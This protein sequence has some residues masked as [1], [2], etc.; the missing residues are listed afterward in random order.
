MRLSVN[1]NKI[2]LLRNQRDLGFPSV[3]HFSR[4]ALDAGAH[5][6]TVHPRPD[7]RHVRPQD[8]TDLAALL[9]EPA[10]READR[11][12]NIEGNPFEGHYVQLVAAARPAQCTLVPD[13]PDQSTSDHGWNVAENAMRLKASSATSRRRAAG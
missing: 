5:G 1:V 3:V 9:D 2:A 10:Y 4:I 7:Q 11:E 6:I 13:D 8:V 12:F